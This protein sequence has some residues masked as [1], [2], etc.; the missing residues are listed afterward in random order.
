MKLITPKRLT[1]DD[2][3][4][5]I[6]MS[7]GGAGELPHRYLKG[8]ERLQRIFNLKVTET[9]N[10]LQPAQWIYEH[11]E[12][13]AQDL[14]E[15]FSDPSVKAVISNIGGD[16]S[17]RMLKYIDL[18]IIKN[19]PKIFLGFSDS[20][21]THFICLKAGLGS[22]YGTSLLVGFAENEAM[23]KYQIDD[24]NR[25]LFSPSVIGQ[26]HPNKEGWT[27]EFLDWF[28]ISLQDIKRTLTPP[29]G[30]RFI[31]GNSIV[32]GPLIGG[33]MEVL[34][35]LKGTD[36]WPDPEVW[37]GCILFLKLQKINPSRNT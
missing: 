28:D 11:P 9:K 3:V 16:D 19:N 17:I 8:K 6:S 12:A 23:H 35:M 37:K 34:E 21:I 15:A 2:K 31:R 36:Y 27:T 10:A 20:T 1:S 13:R 33:C 14:M 24:I 29:A 4:A 25:T 5:T 30:W 22:F 32:Q 7:W 18:E 26:V